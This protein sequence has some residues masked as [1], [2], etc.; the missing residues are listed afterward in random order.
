MEDAPS[1]TA[2]TD[3]TVIEDRSA[4][5]LG[6]DTSAGTQEHDEDTPDTTPAT[7]TSTTEPTQQRVQQQSSESPQTTG[8]IVYIYILLY[9]FCPYVYIIC[10]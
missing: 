10:I 3:S 2:E 1:T 6:Q 8:C 7:E 9:I 4:R 5:D